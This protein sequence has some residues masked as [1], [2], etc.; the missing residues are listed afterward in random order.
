M[1]SV[2]KICDTD[3]IETINNI[4]EQ[5]QCSMIMYQNTGNK[6]SQLKTIWKMPKSVDSLSVGLT[7]YAFPN[8]GIS[9]KERK[10]FMIDTQH[11][12][13]LV[14]ESLNDQSLTMGLNNL[15]IVKL[16]G[17]SNWQLGTRKMKSLVNLESLSIWQSTNCLI[18]LNSTVLKS[19]VLQTSYNIEI[20]GSIAPVK[21]MIIT[22]TK[23]ITLPYVSFENKEVLIENTNKLSFITSNMKSASPLQYKHIG[24]DLFK[25]LLHERIELPDVPPMINLDSKYFYMKRLCSIS[26]ELYWE[27]KRLLKGEH[28]GEE[29]QRIP[30][31]SHYF[32]SQHYDND[33][34]KQVICYKGEK[35]EIPATIRYYEIHVSGFSIISFGF[36]YP[37]VK[38]DGQ[39]HIGVLAESVGLKSDDGKFYD[40]NAIGKKVMDPFGLNEDVDHYVGLGFDTKSRRIFFT[41][42]GRKKCS[43]KFDLEEMDS[44]ITVEEY[45]WLEVNYGEKEFKFDLIEE[46]QKCSYPIQ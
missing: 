30:V 29:H 12:T 19:L 21:R 23:E 17:V 24:M 37:L 11:L 7:Q 20:I 35:K 2:M 18:F 46:Y 27:E 3:G 44:G 13:A 39:E 16:V 41:L 10:Q 15:K 33:N 45:D 1:K 25:Q 22:S 40:G 26:E 28:F 34:L 43:K 6:L 31:T 42:D 14:I 5:T 32:Y 4:I 38:L 36:Y 8:P 9:T